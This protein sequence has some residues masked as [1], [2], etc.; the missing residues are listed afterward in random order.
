MD[1]KDF[2]ISEEISKLNSIVSYLVGDLKVIRDSLEKNSQFL[3]SILKVI[4]EGR[5]L[6]S[7]NIQ[8][9]LISIRVSQLDN[10]LKDYIAKG[11]LSFAT[12]IDENSIIVCKQ[13]NESG[14]EINRKISMSMTDMNDDFKKMFI[15][16]KIGDVVEIFGKETENNT[17]NYFEIL[18]LYNPTNK[19]DKN[20]I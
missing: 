3:A 18:E 17:K 11:F 2:N 16:K 15:Q 20:S 13:T 14:M 5:I 10:M 19:L 9:C 12:F 7:E 6:N 4:E 8:D 1:K